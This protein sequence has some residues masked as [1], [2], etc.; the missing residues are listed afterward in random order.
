[1]KKA[2]ELRDHLAQWVP[3]LKRNPDKLSL[4][5]ESGKIASKLGKSLS[6]A[7]RYPL[8]I[9]ITDFAEPVDVLIV[10][11]L[12]WIEQHQPDLLQNPDTREQ[13]ITFDAEV[14]DNDKIDIAITLNLSERVI[15]AAT[16]T[17]YSCTHL[18]EPALPDLSGPTV[19]QI[20]L[21]GEL[22]GEGPGQ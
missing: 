4:F 10:P 20:Y 7:Y 22:I 16:D 18:G 3:D 13:L 8:K 12:A 1:M 17:G 11:L 21:K 2:T 19:W 5:I 9:L 6:F 15:V 14:L